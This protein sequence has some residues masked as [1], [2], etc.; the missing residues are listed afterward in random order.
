MGGGAGREEAPE[1]ED[2]GDAGAAGAAVACAAAGEEG[3]SIVRKMGARQEQRQRLLQT[4]VMMIRRQMAKG[5]ISQR[6]VNKSCSRNFEDAR[7]LNQHS[8]PLL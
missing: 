4:T 6:R 1:G 8:S 5:P 7:A 3:G 2:A